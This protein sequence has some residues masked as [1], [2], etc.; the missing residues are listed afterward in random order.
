MS[1]MLDNIINCNI[2]ITTPAAGSESFGTILII[3]YAPAVSVG[4]IKSVD[5]YGSLE[6]ITAKGWR[7]EDNMYQAAKAVWMQEPK[8]Q[9]IYIALRGNSEEDGIEDLTE[10]LKRALE[11]SGWYGLVLADAS[12][13]EYE[14][15]ASFIEATEKIFA[16]CTDK[17]ESPLTT[18]SYMRTIGI[19][20]SESDKFIHAAWLAKCFSYDPGSETWAFKTLKGMNPDVLTSS[21]KKTLEESGLNYYVSCAGRDITMHGK[22]TGGEWIDVIRFRDWLKNEMQVRIFNLFVTNPKIPYTDEGISL[23]ENQMISVLKEGQSMGGIADTSYDE[24][25]NEVPG[26]TVKVPLSSSLTEAQRAH[27]KL[28]GCSFTA[29]LSGAIHMVELSGN[30][31]F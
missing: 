29:R 9:N 6:E 1:G 7:E 12:E 31:V 14:G 28:S 19:Y 26:Y 2:S 16:F 25:E 11:T 22:M 13:S 18:K 5:V 3:G 4:E 27:R 30:L 17:K 23:I 10:V 15:V 21:D 24:S 8:P 20:S